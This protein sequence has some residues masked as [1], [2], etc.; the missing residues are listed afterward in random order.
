MTWGQ[1]YGMLVGELETRNEAGMAGNLRE[2]F[3]EG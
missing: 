3:L 2:G 1:K